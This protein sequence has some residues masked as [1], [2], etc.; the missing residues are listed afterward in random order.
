[1]KNNIV[2][3]E[4]EIRKLNDVFNSDKSEFVAIYGRRRVGKTFLVREMFADKFTFEISGIANA[5]TK[6]QLLNFTL[7]MNQTFDR[8]LPPAV[9]WLTA[10][11]QLSDLVSKSPAKRKVLFFD[12]IPW[13]DT[14]RSEFLEL[15]GFGAKRHCFDC[16]RLGYFV[17]YQ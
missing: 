9:N 8:Q 11:A 2:G 10:F 13:I 3:R 4:L 5:K 12:E 17:D 16:L 7:T 6:S 15:L 14:P 1:M